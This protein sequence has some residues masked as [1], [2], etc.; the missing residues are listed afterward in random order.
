V[1]DFRLDRFEI[2]V[3]RFRKFVAAW[4]GGWRPTAGAGKHTHLNSGNG[5][6]DS[7]GTTTYEQGWSSSWTSNVAMTTAN[8]QCAS[9]WQTWTTSAGANEDMPMVCQNWYE[10]YAFCIWDGGFLPSEAEWNY[11]ASG[12]SEQRVYPWS[13]PA[14]SNTVSCS[15]ANYA[16]TTT[17]FCV[18]GATGGPNAVGSESTK[19]DGKFGQA[20][21]AGN[22]NE[23]VLDWYASF[24][25]TCNNCAYLPVAAA[26]KVLRGGSFNAGAAAVLASFR[27]TIG[28]TARGARWGSRC[29]RAP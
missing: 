22:A 6:T 8:L 27:G 2:T 3:G 16:P 12:G 15:Y 7:S 23:F 14:N 10:D 19:G 4:N 28:P 5:L 11:A 24:V 26:D 13:S 29:A 1:N 9:A 17:T 18:N 25:P 21:L 20:D